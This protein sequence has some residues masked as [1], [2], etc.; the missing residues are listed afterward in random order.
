[1]SRIGKLPIDLPSG[2]TVTV[3]DT[4]E[5]KVKGPK[6]ELSLDLRPEIDLEISDSEI[7]AKVKIKTKSSPAFW[8][9]TRALINNMIKGVMEEY[10][11]KVKKEPQM[12]P[13]EDFSRLTT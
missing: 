11:K 9:M 6:G 4:N 2:V 1:M 12:S 10:E 8:G 3:S 5:V 7:V 13:R